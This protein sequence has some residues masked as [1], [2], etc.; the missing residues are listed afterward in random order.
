[1]ATRKIDTQIARDSQWKE[2]PIR[3]RY[4]WFYLLTT[5]FSTTIGI[6]HLPLNIVAAETDLDLIE[7]KQYLMELTDMGIVNYSPRTSEIVIFNYAK[8]NIFGWNDFMK[9]Q[10]FKELA[11][12]KN[13]ELIK[14]LVDYIS[15][16]VVERP[17]DPRS[18]YLSQALWACKQVLKPKEKDY[19]QKEKKDKD[20]DNYV[21]VDVDNY[22]DRDSGNLEEEWNELLKRLEGE[23]NG[24]N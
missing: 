22:I 4:F 24:H 12:V 13:I 17:N 15:N 21:D 3:V 23:N 7:I 20:I 18:T 10:V 14:Q 6:F 5:D 1:M 9:K 8:Y 2:M 11:K 16:Y 19:T